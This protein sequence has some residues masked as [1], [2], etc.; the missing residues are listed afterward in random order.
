[1]TPK[2]SAILHPAKR[3]KIIDGA[4]QSSAN[5][6]MCA[7]S[8]L[9]GDADKDAMKIAEKLRACGESLRT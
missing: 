5:D 7:L 8:A 2:I 4:E 3:R 9:Y 1:M 6:E